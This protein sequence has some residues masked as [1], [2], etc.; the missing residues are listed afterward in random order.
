VGGCVESA[1]AS[2]G[3][4]Y[5][6]WMRRAR[7]SLLDLLRIKNEKPCKSKLTGC[8]RGCWGHRWSPLVSPFGCIVDVGRGGRGRYFVARAKENEKKKPANISLQVI[9]STLSVFV[10]PEVVLYLWQWRQQP[11]CVPCKNE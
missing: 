5:P 9:S 2:V 4:L 11:R 3:H 1:W 7:V 6:L 10:L 8:M